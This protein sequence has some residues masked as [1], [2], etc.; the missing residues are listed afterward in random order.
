MRDFFP[1]QLKNRLIRNA[2]PNEMRKKIAMLATMTMT[3]V[4]EFRLP[5][6]EEM[7]NPRRLKSLVPWVVPERE[8]TRERM[9]M[10]MMSSMIEAATRAEPTGVSSFPS[11]LRTA[12]V[13]E[14]EVAVRMTP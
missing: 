8:R 3:S 11:S 13:T 14:T 1:N 12:T 9:T 4:T 10:P 5:P 6:Q 7:T 2:N